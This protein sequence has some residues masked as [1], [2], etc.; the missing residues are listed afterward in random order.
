MHS[1]SFCD[2][3]TTDNIYSLVHL[4]EQAATPK[5]QQIINCI[6]N[7]VQ[8]GILPKDYLLPSIN[9]FSYEL[10]LSRSTVQRIFGHL[11][12]TGVIDSFPGKG[13]FI[14]CPASEIYTK[15]FLLFDNLSEHN[16]LIYETLITTLGKQASI[17]F[18]IYNN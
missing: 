2:R 13:Y 5:F 18:Y 16:K 10:N 14:N 15:V 1:I 17:D 3:M 8:E 4:D 6:T 7:A 11:K 12:K 9:D